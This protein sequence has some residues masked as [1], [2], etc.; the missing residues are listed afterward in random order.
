MQQ[1][2]QKV[3]KVPQIPPVTLPAPYPSVQQQ[4]PLQQ[5]QQLSVQ[6]QQQHQQQLSVQQV[7]LECTRGVCCDLATLK[8]KPRTAKCRYAVVKTLT[9]TFP[10]GLGVTQD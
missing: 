1:Q 5:Q 8:F 2:Q 7:A 9:M 4:Q 3:F 10:L 6:Q